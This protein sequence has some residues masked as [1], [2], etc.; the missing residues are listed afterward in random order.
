MRARRGT[1][2]LATLFTVAVLATLT[3]SVGA[4]ARSSATLAVNRRAQAVATAM[5]ESGV[6]AA[7]LAVESRLRAA[8]DD[9]SR[10]DALYDAIQREPAWVSDT[11]EDGV[12]ATALVNVTAR[13][14]VNR[15]GADELTRLFRSVAPAAEASRA[16]DRIASRVTGS[17]ADTP[18]MADDGQRR[19]YTRDSLA[20]VLL[21]RD[22]TPAVAHPFESLDEMALVAGDGDSSRVRWL[23]DVASDLTVDG[24]GRV[25]RRHASARVLRSATGSM[26]DRPT[27]LLVIARGWM[28]GHPLTREIQAVYAIEGAELRLVRWREREP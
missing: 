15:A 9:S 10:L 22:L 26:V 3:A 2:L 17:A 18:A 19:Q 1:A 16:A 6:L 24:D 7:R 20:A 8:G 13:L 25:D 12:F 4:R 23:A 21:G 5:A 11:L 28:R 14:D 27:R